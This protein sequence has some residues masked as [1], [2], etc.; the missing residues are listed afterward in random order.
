[1]QMTPNR[2]RVLSLGMSLPVAAETCV[3]GFKSG[4]LD[5]CGKATISGCCR[6][7]ALPTH[8]VFMGLF[9]RT[10]K[11]SGSGRH[12]SHSGQQNVFKDIT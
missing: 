9:S 2:L 1:M 8:A 11:K 6:N 4:D 3:I 12:T 7:H 5:G 10:S